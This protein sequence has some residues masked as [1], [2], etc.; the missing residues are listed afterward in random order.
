MHVSQLN[1]AE[2][3]TEALLA[4]LDGFKTLAAEVV[5]R[6]ALILKV[7]RARRQPHPL[8]HDRILRFWEHLADQTLSPEAA[9][10]LAN[11]NTI[12]AILP[13]PRQDQVEIARGR[14]I[15][16]AEADGLGAINVVQ[17]PINR[18]DGPTLR[19]VFG[20][21]GIRSVAQQADCLAADGRVQR[22]GMITV[23]EAEQL[24][25]IGN[26]KIRP[27]DLRGPLAVLGYSLDLTRRAG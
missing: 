23:I 13:L 8:F 20:P 24:L 5:E 19:R 10:L 27:E 21:D 22:F 17:M 6:L 16:V 1:P 25:K 3:T 15:P 7:L 2:M 26:Q 11:Q 4:E 18:M 9:V 12:R 14:D